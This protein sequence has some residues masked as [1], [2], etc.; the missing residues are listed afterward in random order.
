MLTALIAIPAL[1]A[2]LVG[3]LPKGADELAKR[4]ALAVTLAVAVVAIVAAVKFDPAA[5]GV[6]YRETYWWIQ[7]FGGHYAV[8]GDGG[9]P[10][11]IA[12]SA[13]LVAG[14]GVGPRAA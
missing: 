2:L 11:L 6:D 3:L 4:I 5:G 14:R 12:R 8:G 7:S 10:G 1:G 13:G 9:G